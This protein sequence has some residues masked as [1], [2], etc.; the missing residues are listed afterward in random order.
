MSQFHGKMYYF[1]IHTQWELIR[2]IPRLWDHCLKY[3]KHCI[4]FA[5]IAA[6][7]LSPLFFSSPCQRQ[8]ELLP[9]LDVRRPLTFP[10]LIFSSETPQPNELKL[11]RKHLWKALYKDYSFRPYRLTNMAATGKSCFLL[12]NF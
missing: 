1:F 9:S 7:P 4:I 6:H 5:C 11:C 2:S 10:I 8:G 12:V 3:A